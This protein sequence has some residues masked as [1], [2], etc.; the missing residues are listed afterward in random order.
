MHTHPL[1]ELYGISHSVDKNEKYVISLQ[2]SVPLVTDTEREAMSAMHL[3]YRF[4]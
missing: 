4:L 3:W 2:K 1:Y